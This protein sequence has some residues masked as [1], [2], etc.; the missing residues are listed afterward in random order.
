MGKVLVCGSIAYD[1]IMDFPGLFKEQILPDKIHS[2]NVSFL[3][4]SMKRVK[5]GTA[6]NIAYSLSLLGEK[7]MILGTAGKDFYEYRDWLDKNG[8]DTSHI[9]IAEDD[10]TATCYITTDN[11]NNQITGFYPGAMALDPQLSLKDM[12]LTGISLVI[13][14]PTEP[15]AMTKWTTECQQLGISYIYD[16]GMQI[17]RLSPKDLKDGILGAKIAIFNEYEYDLMKE[18]TGLSKDQILGS[19]DIL[20]VTMGEKG[21]LISGRNQ[22]VQVSV[23]KPKRVVDPTGAGDA[24]RAGLIKGYLEG[25]SLEKM[26]R[27]AS[28][29]AVFAVE[30]KGATEH[31]YTIDEYKARY[32]ENYGEV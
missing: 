10:Y 18:K 28:V 15:E 22:M 27:Y 11:V 12:D 26:G 20:I 31:H 6:P 1:N 14:A 32:K 4:K 30:H 24:F 9:K 21:S 17:P 13:I 3:V 29:S 8:V 23:A 7:P 16:P 5:G 25:S 19:V 2:L